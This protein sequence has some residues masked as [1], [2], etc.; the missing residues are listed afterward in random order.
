MNRRIFHTVVTTQ[1]VVLFKRILSTLFF[2]DRTFTPSLVT[3]RVPK[4]KSEPE[5]FE[6][7]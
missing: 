3:M 4:I 7:Q 6:L 5:N 1:S 2:V